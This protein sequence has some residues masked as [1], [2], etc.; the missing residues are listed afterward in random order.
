MAA[1]G[2]REAIAGL[3]WASDKPRPNTRIALASLKLSPTQGFVLSR[4]DGQASY[5]DIC[6]LTGL[7][8]EATLDILRQ[9]KVQ[10][11]ILGPGE[12]AAERVATPS[13]EGQ[14]PIPARGSSRPAPQAAPSA[15]PAPGASTLER[16]DDGTPV[17]AAEL[18]DWPE[19]APELKARVV[20]LHRRLRQLRPHELLGVAADADTAT[21]KRAF[22]LACKELH[23]DRYFGKALGAFRPKLAAIFSRLTEASQEMEST[24]TPKR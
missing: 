18:L 21:V 17:D 5:T 10:G 13:P 15:K 6:K 4:V 9:L 19:A 24:R 3:G 11:L 7:S 14:R 8:R 22:A 2:E 12:I 16:L 1:S 23:P 20:R